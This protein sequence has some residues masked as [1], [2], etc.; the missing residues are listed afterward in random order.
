MADKEKEKQIADR[1]IINKWE[2][3]RKSGG[4]HYH[5]S[6]EELD[7]MI[8]HLET[9]AAM[10]TGMKDYRIAQRVAYMDADALRNIKFSRENI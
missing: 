5:L 4:V 6:D 2:A 1:A 3:W 8:K 9:I 10:L 7:F